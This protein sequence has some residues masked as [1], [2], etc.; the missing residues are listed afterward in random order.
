MPGNECD[1]KDP[2]VEVTIGVPQTIFNEENLST[3]YGDIL[4][5]IGE[6]YQ[7]EG[8]YFVDVKVETK[9][10]NYQIEIVGNLSDGLGKIRGARIDSFSGPNSFEHQYRFGKLGGFSPYLVLVS[11]F[12]PIDGNWNDLKF[13]YF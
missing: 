7:K 11:I 2:G 13:K 1:E 6:L 10:E 4:V 5:S 12:N 8:A 9:R 3:D